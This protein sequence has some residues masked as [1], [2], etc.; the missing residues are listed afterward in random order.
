MPDRFHLES[1]PIQETMSLLPDSDCE[2]CT[3]TLQHP[4]QFA[5]DGPSAKGQGRPKQ[6]KPFMMTIEKIA[7]FKKLFEEQ[8]TNL[9]YTA[10]GLTNSNFAIQSEDL[11]D[12]VDHTATELEQSMRMR[13]R[14]REALYMRKIDEALERIK[15]GNFGECEDCGESIEARRLEARPTTT[16]CV[17]CKED[18]ERLESAHID[19]HRHKSLGVKMR[20]A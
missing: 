19:G 13:L 10:M 3:H 18:S 5:G 4:I 11:A 15:A 20:F 9:L 12:E 17:S 1:L 8:K 7:Q 16:L 2:I 6:E 14:N